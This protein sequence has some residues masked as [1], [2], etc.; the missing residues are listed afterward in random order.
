MATQPTLNG[1]D[2]HPSDVKVKIQKI[3][4]TQIAAAGGRTF[5]HRTTGGGAPI[6]KRGWDLTFNNVTDAVRSTLQDLAII[7]T[8]MPFV[9]V[10]GVSYTV[11]TEEDC[12]NESVAIISGG[13]ALT[14][15]FNITLTLWQA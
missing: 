8:T 12:Y 5:L 7:A 15:Y 11:Q 1:T 13:T 14:L 10:H 3:G 9:D 2:I 4:K 6:Y